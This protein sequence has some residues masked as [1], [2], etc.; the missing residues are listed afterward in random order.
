MWKAKIWVSV[1]LGLVCNLVL[2]PAAWPKHTFE[3]YLLLFSQFDDLEDS[4]AILRQLR[5]EVRACE[6]E[7]INKQLQI[8][9]GSTID[10]ASPFLSLEYPLDDLS[11][12]E[13]KCLAFQFLIQV[14]HGNASLFTSL[15]TG[16]RSLNL[17]NTTTVES[18][19]LRTRAL[20][21]SLKAGYRQSSESF[22]KAAFDEVSKL[23]DLR[24]Q[25]NELGKALVLERLDTYQVAFNTLGWKHPRFNGSNSESADTNSKDQQRQQPS[26]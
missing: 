4:T 21:R 24:N 20:T 6:S 13:Q 12:Q 1:W 26:R 3:D 8:D 22:K 5:Y 19:D 11:N 7:I 15:S 2:S 17:I 18:D 25:L 16:I 14:L 23:A 10:F 9:I